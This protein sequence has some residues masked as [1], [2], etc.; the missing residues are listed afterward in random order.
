MTNEEKILLIELTLRDIRN[1]W[2]AL[3]TRRIELVK[4]LCEELCSEGIT[5]F[6]EFDRLYD[7]C[8]DAINE[9]LYE[10]FDGRYFRDDFPYGYEGIDEIH[11]FQKPYIFSER[12]T[13]FQKLAKEF[14]TCIDIYFEDFKDKDFFDEYINKDHREKLMKT[15]DLSKI[16]NRVLVKLFLSCNSCDECPKDVP[17]KFHIFETS[18]ELEDVALT[19]MDKFNNCED[20]LYLYLTR[21]EEE[22]KE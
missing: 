21:K 18:K 6:E 17:C 1:N 19:D 22:N 10:K 12:S 16:A 9:V 7:C 5:E 8:E 13:D 4:K 14:L 11:K 3:V 15:I 20:A 2:Y